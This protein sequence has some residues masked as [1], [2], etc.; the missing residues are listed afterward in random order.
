MVSLGSA[1]FVIYYA[2]EM[3][4]ALDLSEQ[5]T[6]GNFGVNTVDDVTRLKEWAAGMVLGLCIKLSAILHFLCSVG[7]YVIRSRH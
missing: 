5:V 4:L 1:G 6:F 3:I 7:D 2:N